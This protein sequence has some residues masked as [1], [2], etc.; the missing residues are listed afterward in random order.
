VEAWLLADRQNVSDYFQIA[1]NK[2]PDKVEEIVHP[3]RALVNAARSSRSR[4][5]RE[6]M[7]PGSRSRATVGPGY[8]GCLLDFV[9]TCW[10]MDKAAVN[11]GSLRSAIRR[12]V[13][14][15]S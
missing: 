14:L 10:D 2:V 8:V 6:A 4:A 15:E 12:L 11:S 3:K 5:I 1:L 13:E 9:N 7:V